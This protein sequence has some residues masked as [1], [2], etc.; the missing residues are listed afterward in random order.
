[1]MDGQRALEIVVAIWGVMMAVSPG[2]QIRQTGRES[3]V[4]PLER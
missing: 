4:T 3:V 2:L 1:M